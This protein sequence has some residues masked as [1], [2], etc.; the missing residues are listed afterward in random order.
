LTPWQKIVKKISWN[1]EN[2][3]GYYDNL[4]IRPGVYIY[5]ALVESKLPLKQLKMNIPETLCTFN[6]LFWITTSKHLKE[7]TL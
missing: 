2:N 4:P 6:G 5:K 1:L 3:Y 7:I